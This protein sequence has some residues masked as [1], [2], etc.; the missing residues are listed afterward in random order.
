MED[1][2]R[3]R[4]AHRLGDPLALTH[5]L[6]R[7][8]DVDRLG[9]AGLEPQ[10][11]VRTVHRVVVQALR[12]QVLRARLLRHADTLELHLDQARVVLLGLPEPAGEGLLGGERGRRAV[13]L[14]ALDLAAVEGVL[15]LRRGVHRAVQD[16]PVDPVL[17]LARAEGDLV[18]ADLLGRVGALDLLGPAEGVGPP[19]GG[20]VEP[21]D[22]L[23]RLHRPV[24]GAPLGSGLG[25]GALGVVELRASRRAL[26]VLEGLDQALHPAGLGQHPGVVR[27][28]RDAVVRPGGEARGDGPGG[29]GLGVVLHRLLR[30]LAQLVG[31]GHLS[32]RA[33]SAPCAAR[34]GCP[35]RR[36]RGSSPR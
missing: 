34:A 33:C 21:P 2:A 20:G 26:V 29:R 7:P 17:N 1:R 9:R 22:V 8:G 4:L 15:V 25:E 5:P 36:R 23:V 35:S 14:L 18:R 6:V 3:Q 11:L 13:E 31:V 28:A 16:A 30:L 32:A 10:R 12:G 27:R 19:V 24:V